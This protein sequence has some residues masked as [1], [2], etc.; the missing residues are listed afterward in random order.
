M[1][2]TGQLLDAAVANNA[3]WCAA[4][5]GAHGHPGV[6]GRRLW[7]SPGHSVRF[8]PHAITL[9]P[10]VS[11]AEMLAVA[12]PSGAFAVKDSYGT[13]D[14]APA[15]FLLQI[16]ASWIARP[17][18][19]DPSAAGPASRAAGGTSG[20]PDWHQVTSPGEL[21]V[22]EAA[23]A[24]DNSADPPV[25]TRELLADPRCA[26]LA[27]RRDDAI[28]HGAIPHGGIVAG[29]IGYAADGVAG[30]SNVFSTVHPGALL[31]TS[32]PAAAARLWP[33]LPVVGY[34]DGTALDAARQAGFDTI[35]DLRIWV[36]PTAL[37]EVISS[38]Q[39]GTRR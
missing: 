2:S 22:W 5:C 13:L 39:V 1:R 26:V 24:G 7:A 33:S 16:Q 23:W 10:A 12:P 17:A 31:F 18:A 21:A 19:A 28:P 29:A 14:L 6:R 30:I 25:F 4:V 36:R 37:G 8:Y 3:S 20:G 27:C 34:E 15:G 38:R 9:S 32:L 11:A 35:G